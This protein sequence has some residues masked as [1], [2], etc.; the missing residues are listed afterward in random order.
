MKDEGEV[1]AKEVSWRG[2]GGCGRGIL[3]RRGFDIGGM[4]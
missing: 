1:R 3:V 2:G 4:R